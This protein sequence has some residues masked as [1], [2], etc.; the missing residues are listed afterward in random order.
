MA[1]SRKTILQRAR[2]CIRIEM[3][4]LAATAKGLDK[5]FVDVAAAIQSAS[6]AGRKLIFSGIGNPAHIAQKL[7]GTFNSTG[8]CR[9][10]FSMLPRHSMGIWA[11]SRRET[12]RS[13]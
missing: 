7:C 6:S 3:N 13:C 10:V 11:L 1:L 4:A 5:G 12:S 2:A 8:G 9:P